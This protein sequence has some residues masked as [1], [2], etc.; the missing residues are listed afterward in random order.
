MKQ[1]GW[2]CVRPM[3]GWVALGWLAF[4]LTSFPGVAATEEIRPPFGFQWGE[5]SERVEHMLTQAKA[6]VVAREN[7]PQGVRLTVEGIS[8]RMLQR[9]YFSFNGD[10]L[11]EIELHYGEEAWDFNHY[12]RFFDQTRRHI[13]QRYGAGRLIARTKSTQSGVTHSLIGYQWTQLGGTLQLFFFSAEK[14]G[15]TV[16]ILSLHYRAG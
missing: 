7:T 2:Q 12:N 4:F 11:E 15:H 6:R 8:Q 1:R 16:K 13:D 9:A 5:T 10:S 3:A 14:A